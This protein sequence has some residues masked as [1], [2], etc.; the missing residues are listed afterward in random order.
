MASEQLNQR[1]HVLPPDWRKVAWD[2]LLILLSPLLLI[3]LLGRLVR[4]KS[5]Q[6]LRERLGFVPLAARN[7]DRP[8]EPLIWIHACS[9]GEVGATEP[10]I[11]ELHQA[12]PLAHV[13]LSTITPTGRQVAQTRKLEV[14][15][16]LYFPLDFP[17]IS[18]RVL[19]AL[20]PRVVVVAETELWP[21]FFA[22]AAQRGIPVCTV[23]GRLSDQS[24]PR[25]RLFRRL[26]RWILGHLEFI[27][28]QSELDA[29]RF[30]AL[31]ADPDQVNI[32]GNSKFDES[33]PH[34]P[35][36][37][38]AKWRQ[39]L[40]F[41]QEQPILVAAS[42]HP[43]EEELVLACYERLR[44]THPD[45]GLLIAPRHPERGDAIATLIGEYG[46]GCRRR[47]T[48]AAGGEPAVAAP[49]ARVQVALLDTIGEL[50]EVYSI[51]TV[52]FM[53]GSLVN[54]GGHNFLQPMALHRPVIF[55][56]HMH[57]FWDLT[58]MA[59]REGAAL[60][61]ANPE[62]LCETVDRLLNFEADRQL[63]AVKAE[64][65]LARN[66]GAARKMVD[67]IVDLLERT[68]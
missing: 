54:I 52:V 8:D 57:N 50:G 28:V 58:G 61:V 39:D 10:I 62:E 23:N 5:L 47:S 7:L 2:A 68:L 35:P 46:Y 16:L 18:E 32:V 40:G 26:T 6:G 22:A 15:A 29:Q 51:A 27:C 67:R 38:A 64:A 24:F 48:Q 17:G 55:G 63:L 42:T 19:D 56:P 1:R 37:G 30:L 59:L 12:E 45:L 60:Q 25:Y 3:Y 20:R 43:R 21:N 9:A 41:T 44:A 65:L 11:R 49:D 31:G 66:T 53:G 14:E 34:V 13:V 4:G 36:E 33:F